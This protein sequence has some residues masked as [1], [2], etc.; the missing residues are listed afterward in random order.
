[1]YRKSK[2]THPLNVIFRCGVFREIN[3]F[4]RVDISLK[5]AKSILLLQGFQYLLNFN[6]FFIFGEH[7]GKNITHIKIHIH[8][9]PSGVNTSNQN[10][11]QQNLYCLL[12][13]FIFLSHYY[14]TLLMHVSRFFDKKTSFTVMHGLCFM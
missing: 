8:F 9:I 14:T 3:T 2:L 1:M 11:K 12:F 7:R 6:S 13:P 4:R 10:N 5:T